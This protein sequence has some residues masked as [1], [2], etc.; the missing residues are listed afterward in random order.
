MMHQK[1]TGSRK[2]HEVGVFTAQAPPPL[3]YSGSVASLYKWP[4][5][6]CNSLGLG[7]GS[8]LG[9]VKVLA[10]VFSEIVLHNLLMGPL[11]PA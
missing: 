11:N 6:S 10:V 8:G 1:K 3:G 7:R 2:E 9:M 5:S 4:P